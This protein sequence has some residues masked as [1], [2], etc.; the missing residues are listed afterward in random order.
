MLGVKNLPANEEDKRHGFVSWVKKIPWRRKWQ[1]T[2][3]FLP[4]EFHWIEEPGRLQ[5]IG[6]QR[7]SHEWSDLE[8]MHSTP[9]AFMKGEARKEHAE[10]WIV[11]EHHHYVRKTL[12]KAWHVKQIHVLK[13]SK[14]ELQI[15]TSASWKFEPRA[16]FALWLFLWLMK[17]VDCNETDKILSSVQAPIQ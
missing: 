13:R 5:T 10:T 9:E 16:Y 12:R 15:Q 8:R 11:C 7:V 2:P 1:F 14:N 17:S 3:V 6:A 4:G